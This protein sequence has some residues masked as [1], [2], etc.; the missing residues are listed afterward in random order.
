[1][2]F[3]EEPE[4]VLKTRADNHTSLLVWKI[5][6]NSCNLPGIDIKTKNFTLY[7]DP[8]DSTLPAMLKR[9]YNVTLEQ[10]SVEECQNNDNMFE[11]NVTLRI[12]LNIR[13]FM[14]IPYVVCIID[15]SNRSK[16]VCLRSGYEG[17]PNVSATNTTLTTEEIPSSTVKGLDII[18]YS[19]SIHSNDTLSAAH[20]PNS[21]LLLCAFFFIITK[22]L[23]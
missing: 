2:I 18:T 4:H 19:T 12:T 14:Y 9:D 13:V 17:C 11:I 16:N 15:Y 8:E 21:I 22:S 5:H 10:S 6:Y 23:V 7:P 3:I 1:M 20:Q